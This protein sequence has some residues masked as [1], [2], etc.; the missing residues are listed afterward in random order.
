MSLYGRCPEN[1]GT[2]ADM[3][4]LQG[5][6]FVPVGSTVTTRIWLRDIP[7]NKISLRDYEATVLG[8]VSVPVHSS[9]PHARKLAPLTLLGAST[10]EL[11][12]QLFSTLGAP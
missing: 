2:A 10:K 4:E 3:H 5:F 9:L 8:L 7:G 1:V 11:E 6:D 12:G